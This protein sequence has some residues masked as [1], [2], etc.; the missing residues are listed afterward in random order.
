[1]VV[2]DGMGVLYREA[3]DVEAL[4]I[5]FVREHGGIDDPLAIRG[6]YVRRQSRAAHDD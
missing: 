2:L 1:M 6:R 3:D 5:P 4:L